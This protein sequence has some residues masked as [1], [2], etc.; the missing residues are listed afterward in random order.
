MKHGGSADDIV[1]TR[2]S[3]RLHLER[4]RPR[5][6]CME[7][8]MRNDARWTE[9]TTMSYRSEAFAEDLEDLEYF[10][11]GPAAVR[12]TPMATPAQ[13]GLLAVPV[14]LALLG[15]VAALALS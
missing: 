15:S 7:T 1:L 10:V 3:T 2:G 8:P 13:L 11:A 12:R 14:A 4:L 6:A 5:N 9:T